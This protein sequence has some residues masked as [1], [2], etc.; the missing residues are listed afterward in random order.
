MIRPV[1]AISVIL[2]ASCAG[3][4]ALAEEINVR[5]EFALES[6]TVERT[7]E[8]DVV[9]VEGCELFG[10]PGEPLLPTK[11]VYVSL[12]P[13]FELAGVRISE[14]NQI[15]VPG[16]FD[17]APAQPVRPVSQPDLYGFVP[18]EPSAYSLS[19]AQPVEQLVSTGEGSL[20]GFRVLGLIVYPVQ[21]VAAEKKLLLSTQMTIEV[22]GEQIPLSLE[23][24]PESTMAGDIA[25]RSLVG[26]LVENP[27]CVTQEPTATPL[28]WRDKCDILI[29]TQVYFVS[30]FEDLRDWYY[31]K[32]YRTEIITIDTIESEY[33][34]RDLPV[35]IRNCIKDYYI[36]QGLGWVILGGDAR[37]VP[38][39]RGYAFVVGEEYDLEDYQQC[40]FYYSDL[41]GSWNADSD[42]YWGEYIED[43]I[44]MYPD[45]FVGRVPASSLTNARLL[46][47]KILTYEGIGI[48]AIPTDYL[49]RALFWACKLD[50][51]PTWGGDAK[52][53]ITEATIFPGYWT[54]KT[55]YDRDGTSGKDR[56]LDAM[57]EGY[58]IVNNCGH[59]TY[60]AAS[61]LYDVPRDDKE[62]IMRNDMT[63][64][65][66]EPRYS[67]LYSIGCMFGALDSD[68]L[69]ERFMLASKGGGVA[70]VANSRYGWYSSGSAGNGPSD[71]MDREFFNALF[72]GRNY[73]VGEA[74]AESKVHYIAYSKRSKRGWYGCF[75]WITYGMNLFGSPIMPVWTATPSTIMVDYEPTLRL[76]RDDFFATVT[77]REGDPIRGALVCLTDGEGWLARGTTD[78][79]GE[80]IVDT[81]HCDS[82]RDLDLTV[83]AQNFLP[84]SRVVRGILN[85]DLELDEG[86]VVPRYGRPGDTFTFQVHY[87]D[88]DGD[89]PFVIK[90]E[91]A[92]QYFHLS[93]LEG[94]PAAGTY[95]VEL[96]VGTGDCLGD[97]FHFFAVDGRGSFERYPPTGELNGPGIDDVPPNSRAYSPAYSTGATIAVTYSAE[98]DCA[99]V[100]EVALWFRVDA[101]PWRFSGLSGE[102]PSGMIDF[103]ATKEGT[104]D[105]FSLATDNA[106]NEQTRIART[107]T[108]CIYDAMPWVSAARFVSTP[109]RTDLPVCPRSD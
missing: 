9:S 104:Y 40:D 73:N 68:S 58:A 87:S 28:Y 44:D 101:G 30:S 46:V 76:N 41:N 88:E 106:G 70:T 63:K 109:L 57:D 27:D 84:R 1:F 74:L 21:Y 32:G 42:E 90:A 39:R 86:E 80:V 10:E 5:L 85:T 55:C 23:T 11:A 43:D 96:V 69:A 34:G 71:R 81:P 51:R 98:D 38:T 95:G 62:Y 26:S 102:G 2:L 67:V 19:M 50:D 97:E 35:K 31:R 56:I 33:H 4:C 47:D 54:Y 29:I 78:E 61:A 18:P 91:V 17:I 15:R 89:P 93:L 92:G 82:D 48:E 25:A 72:K 107:D 49:T 13:G 103:H 14:N 64:V 7:A 20:R 100:N 6:V 99:G 24:F 52:D 22:N 75:R 45:V 59:S 94:A 83:T 37:E 60:N 3:L 8:Y 105:F 12:P 65:R 16:E 53:S 36:N 66:N 77:D 79:F 108:T